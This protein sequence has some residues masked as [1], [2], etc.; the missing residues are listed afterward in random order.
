MQKTIGW[1]ILGTGA[2]ARKFGADLRRVPDA[3]LAA[4]GSRRADTAAAFGREFGA[5]RT[6]GSYEELV[7][8]PEVD[9]VY[10]ATPNSCHLPN[11]LLALEAGKPVLCEK[12]FALDAAEA[13]RMIA[14]ARAR[15][16]FLMDA[17]WTR[18]F[19]IL[20]RLQ[21]RIATGALGELKLLTA[22]FGFRG[23][24]AQKRRVFDPALGGGALLDVGVYP[25]AL[26]WLLFGPPDAIV[27][28]A[29]LGPTGVDETCAMIFRYAGGPLAQLSGSVGVDTP[30]E[31]VLCGTRGS[32]RLPCPWW[33]PSVMVLA[34]PGE[35]DE[36]VE[37]PFAGFGY[38][39]EML[40]VMRCLRAGELESPLMPLD[41][42]LAIMKALDTIRAQWRG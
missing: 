20:A 16:L 4:V 26:A 29:R 36:R 8:C 5:R 2:I 11:T 22:D 35:P 9:A 32:V 21:E 13:S 10:V 15:R 40:E 6:F 18:F 39:F 7:C 28:Q 37:L 41:E 14:A 1:G 3:E 38:Q 30:K 19:P 33:R 27:S 24:P 34:Q 17:M 25:V 23:D 12:P 42:T 31:V